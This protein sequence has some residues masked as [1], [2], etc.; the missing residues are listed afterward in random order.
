[1]HCNQVY[2]YKTK[3]K[4]YRLVIADYSLVLELLMCVEN[5]VGVEPTGAQDMLTP[6]TT[7]RAPTSQ[8]PQTLLPSL[9]DITAII[10]ASKECVIRQVQQSSFATS[11]PTV[12]KIIETALSR[13]K[14]TK[15]KNNEVNVSLTKVTKDHPI[16]TSSPGNI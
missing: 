3:E 16:R 14:A 6:T 4:D 11:S 8:T 13:L 9:S 2:H 15:P 10:K 7:P 5:V 1:M 12:S